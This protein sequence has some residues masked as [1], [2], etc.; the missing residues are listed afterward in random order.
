MTHRIVRDYKDQA[1]IVVIVLK[2]AFIFAADLTRRL[3]EQGLR[4]RLDFLRAASYGDSDLSSG[5]VSLQLDVSLPLVN[6]KVLLIDDIIDTGLTLSFL[7]QHLKRKGAT[8]VKTCV[9]L[10]KPARRLIDF[11]PDYIGFSIP[12]VFV[13]G[14]G[15]DFAEEHRCLSGLAILHKEQNPCH[16]SQ[17]MSK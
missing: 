7:A 10:D 17:S 16:Q 14:Y 2:G 4:L 15:L 6:Q 8:E 11:K 13:V 5:K 12:D 1:V 3:A 9:L